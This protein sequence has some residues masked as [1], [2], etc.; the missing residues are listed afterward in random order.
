M[1]KSAFFVER[2]KNDANKALNMFDAGGIQSFWIGKR[3]GRQG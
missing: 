1:K 2:Y 3:Y